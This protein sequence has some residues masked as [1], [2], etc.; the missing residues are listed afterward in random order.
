MCIHLVWVQRL[1]VTLDCLEDESCHQMGGDL[2]LEPHLKDEVAFVA[3]FG[4]VAGYGC[5]A[6]QRVNR[7][8]KTQPLR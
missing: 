3:P 5:Q 4:A 2:E 8:R 6:V 1:D 7:I